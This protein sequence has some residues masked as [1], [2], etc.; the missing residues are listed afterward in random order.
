MERKR[1]LTLSL[2]LVALVPVLLLS[3]GS[4]GADEDNGR[5]G[6]SVSLLTT[7]PIP[8]LVVFDI[9][10]VDPNTQLYYLADRSNAAIEVIDANRDLFVRQIKPAGTQAFKGFTGD[11]NT[12]GPNG[13][14]VSP[15]G[16]WLFVTDGNSRVVSIDLA[17]DQIVGDV[18][19]GGAAGLRTD[20]LAYDA[21]DGILLVVNNADDPP[22]ATVITVNTQ[23]G[24]LTVGPRIMF[25]AARGVD[26]TN[27]AEQP[28]WDPG[29]GK[30][31]VSIPEVNCPGGHNTPPTR[32]CGGGFHEGAVVRIDPH[33]SGTVD[34]PLFSVE[35]C[36]PAGLA[37][38]P[39]QDLLLGCSVVFDTVG[40][41]WDPSE[42]NPA[43]PAQV[44]L[45][46]KTGAIEKRVEGVGGS[47]EVWFNA[48]D[49]RYYTASRSDPLGPVLG[50]IDAES[51]TLIQL[52]PTFNT[53]S[54]SPAP[55][56][57]AHSVAVNPHNNHV[58]VPLPPNRISTSICTNGCVA[59]FGPPK[60]GQGG[61][62]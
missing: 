30:F 26:A 56:G 5:N 58:F 21:R 38:G 17:T 18:H 2:F 61:D 49:R 23:N 4:G 29:T 48:G 24:T 9:S 46:A 62:D 6:G 54:T 42:A 40:K 13:V 16:R 20:E 25:D 31:Y 28:V 52:V 1:S 44:L 60:G 15:D 3:A 59:V 32:P 43:V 55:R 39:Q 8:G 45:D 36:Q 34:T 7:I 35:F 47:D 37:L 41:A 10:W 27:G 51:Q 57:T 11:N 14:V 53:P 33:T 12:S 22:F 50:V 19:T